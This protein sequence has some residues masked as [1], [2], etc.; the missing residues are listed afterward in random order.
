MVSSIRDGTYA[1]TTCQRAHSSG[2]LARAGCGKLLRGQTMDDR[3]GIYPSRHPL[4]AMIADS[5]KVRA[6]RPEEIGLA[7]DWAADEGWNPGLADPACFGT[8][9]P[10]G[11]LL[12][13]LDG[14]PAATISVVNYNANFAFLGFYIARPDLRGRGYGLRIWQAGMAHAGLRTGGLDGVYAQTVNY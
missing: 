1:M 6:M 13:K 11:F 7:S 14:R 5:F 4:P 9:D 8:V 12:G 3:R 10:E 2:R